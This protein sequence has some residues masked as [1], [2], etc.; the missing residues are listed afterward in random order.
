MVAILVGLK[1][2]L[3]RNSLRRSAW[4]TV[5]LVIG[6]LYALGAV[7]LA[8]LG[9]GA[10]RLTS[11]RLTGDVTVLGF[12]VLTPCWLVFSL[13]VFGV[14]ETVDP[15]T[16]ALLPLRSPQLL[17]GLFV[18]GLVGTPGV[19]TLLIAAGLVVAWSR[20]LPATVAT[21][22][23]F[24]LGVATCF[25]LSRAVAA[26]FAS[27][28]SSRRF[29]DFSFLVLALVGAALGMGGNLVGGLAR[30]AGR[31][32]LQALDAAAQVLAWTPFGWAWAVPADVAARQW[33]SAAL[34]MLLAAALAV[35][36]WAVWGYAWGSGWWS[37]RRPVARR[38][39]SGPADSSNGCIPPARPERSLLV[40][41]AAGGGTRA[42]SR[43]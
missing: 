39:G 27:A 8:L 37:R 13:L 11:A 20:D 14:D 43:G 19:A 17:P 6:M 31:E 10:L 30:S 23:A 41:C 38:P 15:S 1:L 25:L 35:G 42:I 29:R 21:V 7:V 12:S 2:T 34:H 9:L 22:V 18:A 26:A 16:F 28:L 40:R 36:L 24:P 33:W 5:G 4:R 3:L 32:Y